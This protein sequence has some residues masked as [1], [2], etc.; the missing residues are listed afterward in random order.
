MSASH[1]FASAAALRTRQQSLRRRK[2]FPDKK[3]TVFGA[4]F[5][6][7]LELYTKINNLSIY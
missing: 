2:K 5:L 1:R 6:Q 3:C 4:N 7:F